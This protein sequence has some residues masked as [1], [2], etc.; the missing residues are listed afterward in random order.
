MSLTQWL[1]RLISS[2]S[3]Q[4]TG[5]QTPSGPEG[6]DPFDLPVW[7]EGTR[8]YE[9]FDVERELEP[10]NMGPIY[11]VR[12]TED[13][14]RY[15]V[16]RAKLRDSQARNEFSSAMT[17]WACLPEHPHLCACRF[18]RSHG[19]ESDLFL[20]PLQGLSVKTAIEEKRLYEGGEPAAL[21]RILDIAIQ[22]AW[23]LQALE[24][25]NLVHGHLMPAHVLL[26][27]KNQVK[28]TD[29]GWVRATRH[30][31]CANGQ[32]APQIPSVYAAPDA[33]GSG[34]EASDLWS[35]AL[36][37]LE[38]FAGTSIWVS[39]PEQAQQDG[40]DAKTDGAG[41][42]PLTALSALE[43]YVAKGAEKPRP[44]MPPAVADLLRRCLAPR[45]QDRC[46]SAI[47][48]GLAMRKAYAMEVGREYPRRAPSSMHRSNQL[49]IAHA[50]W[51]SAS[52]AQ[53]SSPREWE[54]R[55]ERA[56]GHPVMV[57]PTTTADALS[58]Q[59]KA[60]RDHV[61]LERI[62]AEC[63]KRI[64]NG[65]PELR[66][67]L[68]GLCVDHGFL[69]V[70]LQDTKEALGCFEH[71]TTIWENLVEKEQRGDLVHELAM[72]HLN[73]ATALKHLN[74]WEEALGAY[75]KAKLLWKAQ[76][77]SEGRRE[78][79]ATLGWAEALNADVLYNMA[80]QQ[81]LHAATLKK[82]V[83]AVESEATDRKNELQALRKK[84][85]AVRERLAALR[86]LEVDGSP[87]RRTKEQEV[88]H[89]A[90]LHSTEAELAKQEKILADA[91]ALD[92]K[93]K[94]TQQ[95]AGNADRSAKTLQKRAEGEARTAVSVLQAEVKRTDR[96]DVRAVLH[97]SQRAFE[98]LL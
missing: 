98:G 68:A 74:R 39:D 58:L 24:D 85:E 13:E 32:P 36:I 54:D 66:H 27:G 90:A 22:A 71:A 49:A 53:W 89:A 25:F 17:A 8:I 78:L 15:V 23:G 3:P 33:S 19:D 43:Q 76:V 62:Q 21:E 82:Q 26:T 86:E 11:L 60:S 97:W 51:C 79:A 18:V 14:R 92:A 16:R 75:E 30:A 67:E 29:I 55:I 69:H 35:W 72:A 61:A 28:I 50:R 1:G 5:A 48:A 73:R 65:H 83:Q 6:L 95:E 45:L 93:H 41:Q 37:V 70:A 34:E 44:A 63:E 38:M 9:E 77:G 84:V 20:E 56:M 47:E 91:E 64:A 12:S 96:D 59:V 87:Y 80:A 81:R 31:S 2:E 42:T 94:A 40:K 7:S 57:H 10:G 88:E 52:G 46:T 4:D